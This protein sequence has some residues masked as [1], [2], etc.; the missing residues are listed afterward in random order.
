MV[1]QYESELGIHSEEK[2]DNQRIGEGHEECRP[3][4]IPQRSLLLSALVHFLCRVA[5]IS[6]EAK[7]QKH[8]A[9]TYLQVEAILVVID[10]IHHKRHTEAGKACIDDI[11]HGSTHAGGQSEPTSLVQCPLHAKDADGPHRSTCN[12]PDHHPLEDEIQYIYR[13]MYR[14][15]ECKGTKIYRNKREFRNKSPLIA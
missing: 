2:E 10:Q 3:R 6:I 14:H 11:A 13:Y 5:F 12:N 1:G 8:D 15:I 9:T 7:A 4:V